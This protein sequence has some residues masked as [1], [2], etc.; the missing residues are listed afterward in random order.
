MKSMKRLLSL[1]LVLVLFGCTANVFDATCHV[2][3]SADPASLP[4]EYR[5]IL[6]EDGVLFSGD[7]A[8]ESG[9]DLL[10]M[11]RR[12]MRE[13]KLPLVAESGFISAIGG[14]APGG[15]GPM[16][17]WMFTVN[18]EMPMEGCDKIL[19]KDGDV[20]VWTYVTEWDG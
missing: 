17:G 15:A 9:E 20:I 8:I 4:A 12:A 18:G 11:M 10:G 1:A 13:E 14:L 3:I 16:S 5:E 2:T 6:P 19:L 7:V